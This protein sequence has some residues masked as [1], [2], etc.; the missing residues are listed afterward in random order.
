[1]CTNRRTHFVSL[2]ADGNAMICKMRSNSSADCRSVLFYVSTGPGR[3]VRSPSHPI[4]SP[5]RPAIADSRAA[6][7]A[8]T[9]RSV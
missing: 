9:C 3:T 1:M 2:S 4:V 6:C 7:H 8:C 5:R